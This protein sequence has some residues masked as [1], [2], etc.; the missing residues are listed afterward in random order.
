LP[1]E[2]IDQWQIKRPKQFNTAKVY[3]LL[4]S[5]MFSQHKRMVNIPSFSAVAV[6]HSLGLKVYNDK[7]KVVE[8]ILKW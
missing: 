2:G 8:N 4:F 5:L 1:K 7:L 6:L 3:G